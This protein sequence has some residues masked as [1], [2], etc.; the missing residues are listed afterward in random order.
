[1]AKE[2]K[3]LPWGSNLPRKDRIKQFSPRG[4][5]MQKEEF[6]FHSGSCCWVF[7]FQI[8]NRRGI[9]LYPKWVSLKLYVW[10]MIF[11]IPRCL[12]RKRKRWRSTMRRLMAF[13]WIMVHRARDCNL[14]LKSHNSIGILN[15]TVLWSLQTSG[16]AEKINWSISERWS[17]RRCFLWVL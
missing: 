14:L 17:L 12:T 13:L 9:L 1:M 15:G 4:Y 10:K 11:V 8:S 3:K 2:N 7:S 6:H 16:S 5:Q